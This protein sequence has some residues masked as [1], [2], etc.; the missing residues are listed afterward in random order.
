MELSELNKKIASKE[1]RIAVIGLGYVGL[2]VA[3]MFA[4]A[5]FDV[6]G[7][8]IKPERVEKINAG[9]SP[10]EGDEPGLE[11]LLTKVTA[12]KKLRAVSDYAALTGCDIVLIDVETPVDD[13]HTPRY[14]ALT[15]ALRSLAP[16]LKEDALVIIES[17]I[18]PGTMQKTVLP[19]LEAGSGRKVNRGFSLG[20]CPERVMPGK[21]LANLRT[22]SRVAGGSSPQVA[23]TMTVLYRHIVQADLDP[24]DWVTAEL[25]KTVENA[26]RD[27]QIAFA[28]EVAM[29][30]EALGG[31]VWKV[32]ELV[33]KSPYRQMHLPGAGVGGHCIPKDPWL[34]AYGVEGLGVPLRMIPAARAVNDGM[35][36]HLVSLLKDALAQV[37]ASLEGSRVLV[38]GYAYL[39]NSDDTRNSPTQALVERLEQLGASVVVHDPFVGEYQGDLL[40]A[41]ADCDAAV[42]M[43]AHTPY[44]TLPLAALQSALRRPVLV[45]G[46]NLY[47]A[48]SLRAAGWVYRGIGKTTV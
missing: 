47:D 17:T 12:E 44:R 24:V 7:V 23:E 42:V 30:C 45:D 10:I 37:S 40:A 28:N 39:E 4:E 26:Y 32:R 33:N 48:L 29:I 16:V 18:A 25:V 38:M 15:A 31:D 27:V 9:I 14:Q 19:L 21:L 6:L 20:N 34:L 2:P 35:P 5:G 11:E 43:V 41:A 46:R 3:A 13:H 22:L 1:A 8:E 36:L